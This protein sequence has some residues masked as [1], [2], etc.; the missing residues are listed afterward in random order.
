MGWS[1]GLQ[2]ESMSQGGSGDVGR[3]GGSGDV[4]RHGGSGDVGRHGGSG[5][6]GR[7]GGSGDVGRHGGSGA[8]AGHG[9]VR[10]PPTCVAPTCTPPTGTWPPPP[11][12]FLRSSRGSW[13]VHRM[14]WAC[15]L[16]Q[17]LDLQ[18]QRQRL[19][20]QARRRRLAAGPLKRYVQGSGV[21]PIRNTALR[22]ASVQLTRQHT[23]RNSSTYLSN[24]LPLCRKRQSL[25]SAVRDAGYTGVRKIP[26]L[27]VDIQR[28]WSLLL[29]RVYVA[30]ETMRA[31]PQSHLDMA[32]IRLTTVVT[33]HESVV[34]SWCLCDG[35]G[36]SPDCFVWA[37][38]LI[39]DQ[40]QLWALTI[41]LFN[42]LSFVS[43]LSDRCVESGCLCLVF[44]CVPWIGL[45]AAV[46]CFSCSLLDYSLDFTHG[47]TD[48]TLHGS[49]FSTDHHSPR[50]TTVHRSPCVTTLLLTVYVLMCLF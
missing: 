21:S 18:A 10:S 28:L 20:M 42:A 15:G 44:L 47:L 45:L 46:S 33:V 7:H 41:G 34:S 37:S 31:G 9:G 30:V 17:A 1:G 3:H 13:M 23:S 32:R 24:G 27:F 14:A 16:E 11:K 43:C 35:V 29:L 5:D 25:S 2:G 8:L 19:E 40:R 26:I 39:V 38:P 50:I 49:P 36:V 22:L 6:L 12:T 48:T 4:G